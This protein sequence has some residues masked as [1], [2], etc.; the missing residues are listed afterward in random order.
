MDFF[1]SYE[2]GVKSYEDVVKKIR[3][4]NKYDK[5]III[6]DDADF[7]SAVIDL[8]SNRKQVYTKKDFTFHLPKYLKVG[9]DNEKLRSKTCSI[10]Q[11]SF[12]ENEYFRELQHCGHFFHKKC[13]DEWFFRSKTYSCPLCRKNPCCLK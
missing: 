7:T 9:K 3:D 12:K 1:H 13:V 2:L 5:L 11:D 6:N 10:C 4:M 8:G